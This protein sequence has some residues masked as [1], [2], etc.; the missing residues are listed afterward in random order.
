MDRL[1]SAERLKEQMKK[2]IRSL[3]E[4]EFVLQTIDQAPTAG[5]AQINITCEHEACCGNC[6]SSYRNADGSINCKRLFLHDVTDDFFCAYGEA[7]P[8]KGDR[9]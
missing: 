1:I 5:P 7:D 2:N 9:K 3:Y 8:E 6:K 4:I